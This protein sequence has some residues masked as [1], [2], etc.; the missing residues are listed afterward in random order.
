[1]PR[2]SAARPEIR[3]QAGLVQ[4][5]QCA[6]AQ[7]IEGGCADRAAGDDN[8]APTEIDISPDL[9]S[10]VREAG[11][12]RSIRAAP[13]ASDH[14]PVWIALEHPRPAAKRGG[15]HARADH[16]SARGARIRWLLRGRDL[17]ASLV[18]RENGDRREHLHR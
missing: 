14:A 17:L 11:V 7:A 16:R 6:W 2:Q 12:D 1:M 5:P 13:G 10:R 9:T 8:V 18:G 15:T 3:L 4:A